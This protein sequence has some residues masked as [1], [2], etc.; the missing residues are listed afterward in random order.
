[1]TS[2]VT[3]GESVK[4]TPLIAEVLGE[5]G[6]IIHLYSGIHGDEPEAV[7]FLTDFWKME[8]LR[9]VLENITI[10]YFPEVNPDGLEAGT[11]GN[12]NGVDI[13]R[14]FPSKNWEPDSKEK[15]N[16]PGKG[17]ASEPETRG[18]MSAIDRFAPSAIISIHTWTP[19][20][21]FDGPAESLANIISDKNGYTVTGHIGY[22]TPGSLGA[23]AGHDRNIQV[24]TL[25]LPEHTPVSSYW[26]KN[27]K[28]LWS[29][30]KYLGKHE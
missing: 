23:F 25:E 15:K 20:V 7:E 16:Y 27:S 1:M 5:S 13:N 19:Q 29:A 30:I 21:N 18:I 26:K 8:L 11:R 10:L 14:N 9:N 12:A 6:P 3:L 22:P 2:I 17:P 28:A 24:V 4:R